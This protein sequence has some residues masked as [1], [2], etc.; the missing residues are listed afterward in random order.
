[1]QLNEEYESSAL[2]KELS[3]MAESAR[4]FASTSQHDLCELY[5]FKHCSDITLVFKGVHFPV[6]KAIV[7]VRCPAFRELL[8]KKPFGSYVNVNLDIPG[9]RVELFNDLLR[10]LY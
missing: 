6:H 2:L 3:L 7:C 8:G 1:M 10:Y 4:P 5:D 9:L